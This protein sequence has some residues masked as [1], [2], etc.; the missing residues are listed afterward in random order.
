LAT[1]V[2]LQEAV[3]AGRFRADLLSRLGQVIEV[4]PLRQRRADIAPL[5]RHFAEHYARQTKADTPSIHPDAIAW[6]EVQRFSQGDVRLLRDVIERAAIFDR[7]GLITTGC[8]ASAYQALCPEDVE[9]TPDSST[10]HEP[11]DVAL[12]LAS[13]RPDGFTAVEF[14]R[15]LGGDLHPRSYRRTLNRLC[16]EGWITKTGSR[17]D[18]LYLATQRATDTIT[19]KPTDMSDAM[20]VT[21]SVTATQ[22]DPQS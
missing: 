14:A 4:A 8:V 15:A 20:S 16:R 19:D 21:A 9:A 1:N 10:A 18:R 5:A 17:R 11:I 22:E 13:V 7:T 12:Q 3:K 6:L 2:N